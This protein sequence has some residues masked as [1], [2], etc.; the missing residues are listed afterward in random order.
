MKSLLSL[1]GNSTLHKCLGLF[2]S[3]LAVFG[4]PGVA[5][6]EHVLVASLGAGYAA[7]IHIVDSVFNSAKGTGPTAEGT[8][9]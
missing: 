1:L 8:A 7:L 5:S 6:N 9:A 4:G 3:G 2:A